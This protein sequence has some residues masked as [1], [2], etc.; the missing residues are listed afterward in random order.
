[1]KGWISRPMVASF[2][3]LFA[4]SASAAGK[5][6]HPGHYVMFPINTTL[7][8]ALRNISEIGDEPHIKGVEVRI[9]WHDLE[10]SA[11]VYDFSEIDALLRRLKAQPTTKRLV[12]R[13]TDRRYDTSSPNGIVPDYMRS[14]PKY[15]GGVVRSRVGYVARLWEGPVMDRLIALYQ[16]IGWRYDSNPYFE[17]IASEE[18]TLDLG[19]PYPSGYSDAA[20]AHQYERLIERATLALPRSNIF[21]YTN[22]IGSPKLMDDLMQTLMVSRAAAGGSNIFPGKKTLGQAVWTGDYGADYRW[23]LPLS[24]SVESRDLTQ[25]T[26]QQIERWAYNDLHLHYMFWDRNTWAGGSSARWYTGVLPFLRTN[27]PVR[28]NCPASYGICDRH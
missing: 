2:A 8:G 24:S 3:L 23:I 19:Q 27:P 17:G 25:A 10:R 26:P 4:L 13:I 12:V 20:L 5:K 1:M 28:T 22:W 6:W 14:N 11:G 16:H 15:N 9:M 18:T 21:L 7:T